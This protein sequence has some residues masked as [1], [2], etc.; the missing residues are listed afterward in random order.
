MDGTN[1]AMEVTNG[2]HILVGVDTAGQQTG[3]P[4]EVEGLTLRND[5]NNVNIDREMARMSTNSMLFSAIALVINTKFRT[6]RTALT[7]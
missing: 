4:K 2:R 3:A 7:P 1:M 5:L 6:L